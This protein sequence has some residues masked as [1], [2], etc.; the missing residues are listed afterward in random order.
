MEEDEGTA[1]EPTEPTV[2]H[3]CQPC[4][5][6][7][8]CPACAEV[9]SPTPL[10][11]PAHLPPLVPESQEELG[12]EV[13]EGHIVEA[14]AIVHNNQAGYRGVS[15][16]RDKYQVKV[17]KWDAELNGYREVSL[18]P[19]TTD[20]TKVRQHAA[21]PSPVA[22][23]SVVLPAAATP[24][25]ATP[26]PPPFLGGAAVLHLTD[27]LVL[28]VDSLVLAVDSLLL[29]VDSLLPHLPPSVAGRW[30]RW[31]LNGLDG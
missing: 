7:P 12:A 17:R 16:T 31:R 9:P 21:S 29:A 22:S 28:A 19:A 10:P 4:A 24:A 8:L 20:A 13:V 14:V 30:R 11:P 27:S 2:R 26:P 6:P 25:A 23:I 1:A 18:M 3:P 15:M 5:E